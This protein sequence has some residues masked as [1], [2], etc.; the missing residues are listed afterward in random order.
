MDKVLS[1]DLIVSNPDVRSG[2]PV[3]AGTGICVSDVAVAKI[4]HGQDVDGI[5]E[6]YDLTLPQVYAALS[7]YYAHQEEIDAEIQA[8][9]ALFEELKEKRVGSRHEPLFK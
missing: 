5:A 9:D 6:W 3:I 8:R 2:R 1:I 4:F 7:Y